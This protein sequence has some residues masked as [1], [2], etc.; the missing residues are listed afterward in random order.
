[1][2][3]FADTPFPNPYERLSAEA[4]DAVQES[5]QRVADLRALIAEVSRRRRA[6]DNYL[7]WL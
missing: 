6:V 1:M 2:V 4:G 3:E 7:T 5:Q